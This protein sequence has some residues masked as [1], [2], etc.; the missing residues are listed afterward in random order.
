MLP[1]L[2][3]WNLLMITCFSKLSL[4]QVHLRTM[5]LSSTCILKP[6]S[7][8][9][10]MRGT[11]V[12]LLRAGPLCEHHLSYALANAR[13][14]SCL[15]LF[16]WELQ[17]RV[18]THFQDGKFFSLRVLNCYS[19][20]VVQYSGNTYWVHFRHLKALL[21]IKDYLYIL[22]FEVVSSVQCR[23]LHEQR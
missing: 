19:Y 22:H 1:L 18:R 3:I 17:M 14:W 6:L 10:R 20:S 16:P 11:L 8:W 4:I 2:G 5:L 7:V 13:G 9:E 23:S 15:P 21:P 12:Q